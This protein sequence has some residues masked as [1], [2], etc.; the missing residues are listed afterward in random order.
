MGTGRNCTRLLYCTKG[1]NCTETKLH[2]GTKILLHGDKFAPRDNFARRVFL[3][4]NEKKTC[5]YLNKNKTKRLL[6]EGKG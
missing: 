5:I 1:Q 4:K 2:K 6:T 3:H